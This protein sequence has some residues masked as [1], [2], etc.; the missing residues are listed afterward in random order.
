ME[1]Q[2]R[3]RMIAIDDRALIMGI[4]NVTPDS[5]FDGGR[6]LAPEQARDHAVQL[7]EEGADLL[8]LGAESTRPGSGS[9]DE[10][11]ELQRLIPVVR[12]VAKS[13]TVPISVDTSKS[14]VARAAIDAGAAIVNDVT[15]LRGDASMA[16]LVAETGAGVILMHMQG[17]PQTMQRAPQYEDVAED[18]ERFFVERIRYA[19]EQGISGRQIV[20]DPGIG[21]GKLLG[22]NLDLL[23]Q[24]S[25]FGKL[26][27]PVLVGLSRKGF[28]GQLTGRPVQDRLWGTAA[29]VAL[30]VAQGAHIVRVHDVQ[31]MKDVVTVAAAVTK[32][33]QSPL[34]ERQHA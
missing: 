10:A 22:H 7:A 16:Q 1:F 25:S 17:T 27:H 33:I 18:V 21:F 29:V 14:V 2:A 6:Y 4:V 3:Q 31:A 13:V 26:G 28:I 34:R 9:I 12:A 5:F 32:R 11:E 20:L 24:L 30:A 19:A 23:A 8:D 15:A